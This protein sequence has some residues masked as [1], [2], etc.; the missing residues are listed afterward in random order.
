[1]GKWEVKNAKGVVIIVHGTGEHIGRYDW[2]IKQWNNEGYHVVGD[3]LPGAGRSPGKKGHIQSFQQYIDKVEAWYQ[4]AETYKLPIFLFGH[5]LGGLIVI[6]TLIEKQLRVAAA[7]LS[8]PCLKLKSPPNPLQRVGAKLAHRIVP[9][10]RASTKLT[11][12]SVSRNEQLRVEYEKDP[13]INSKV[14]IRWY[15]ELEKAMKKS[16]QQV[17]QFPNVP[18]LILQ[19]GEDLVIDKEGVKKWFHSLMI[20]AKVYKEWP[21]LYHEVFNEQERDE[22]FAYTVKFTNFLLTE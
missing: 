14:S 8:S 1:M 21:N 6:R 19:A 11:F 20:D 5:S 7:I 17:D 10:L 3:D 13:L 12:D 15:Q 22:V 16:F 4:K 9:S 2:L 18:L